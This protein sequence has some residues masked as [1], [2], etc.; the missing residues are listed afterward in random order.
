MWNLWY[1]SFC[2]FDFGNHA[3][4][5]QD[6]LSIPFLMGTSM[7]DWHLIDCFHRFILCLSPRFTQLT[8]NLINFGSK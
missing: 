5:I 8:H 7:C 6:T 3:V 4:Q 2:A 1:G